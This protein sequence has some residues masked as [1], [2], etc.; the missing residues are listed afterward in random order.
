[1]KMKKT[2]IGVVIFMYAVCGLFLSMSGSLSDASQ[3]Y[4][5]FTIGLLFG[6]T[7]LY[8]LTMV[9]NARRNGV[10]SGTEELLDGF[11]GMQLLVCIL[12]TVAYML[13]IRYLGFFSATIL[14][15]FAVLLYLRVPLLATVLSVAAINLLVY[16]AFAKFLGV[17]LPRGLLF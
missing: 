16:F 10:E 8:L 15:M 13:L 11:Q 9:V 2:D 7:T 4:P 17:R 12:L 5:L 3:T 6:L 1:M 14:F